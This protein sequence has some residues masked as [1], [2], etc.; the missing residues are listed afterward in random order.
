MTVLVVT[1]SGD[2]AAPER[3]VRAVRGRGGMAVRLD[4]DAFPGGIRME[5]DP[6]S[7][8]GLLAL[9]AGPVPLRAVKAAWVR[10]LAVGH[11]LPREGLSPGERAACIGESRAAL[12]AM[13]DGLQAPVLGRPGAVAAASDKLRQ[14]RMAE[15]SGLRVPE[16]RVSNDPVSVRT[17]AA[18]HEGGLVAKMLHAFAVPTPDGPQV[19]HTAR[20]RPDDLHDLAG[21]AAA[22][23]VFQQAVQAVR[24]VRAVIVGERVLAAALPRDPSEPVD[25]RREALRLA[26]RWRPTQLPERTERGL[27]SLARRLG[28][29]HGSA[30]LLEDAYGRLWFLELNPAGEWLWLEEGAGLDISGALADALL[31]GVGDPG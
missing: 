21:L 4:S 18:R 15:R 17:L 23:M 14:L 29:A 25:W 7:G 12:R 31:S 16:T 9:P 28:L 2:N 27:L 5:V 3:V 22:P 1:H 26:G 13:L 6:V 20:V 30:D 8:G 10:R 19:V 11:G 24:E